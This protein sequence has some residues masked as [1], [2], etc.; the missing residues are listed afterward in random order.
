MFPAVKGM[1]KAG[2]SKKR[3]RAIMTHLPSSNFP[4]SEEFYAISVIVAFEFVALRVKNH[5]F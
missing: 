2:A 1:L 4:I 5:R 3:I